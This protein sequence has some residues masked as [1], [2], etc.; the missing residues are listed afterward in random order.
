MSDGSQSVYPELAAHEL[1]QFPEREGRPRPGRLLYGAE[2]DACV[3]A[4][5]AWRESQALRRTAA[6][7]LSL[8]EEESPMEHWLR[9]RVRR[10]KAVDRE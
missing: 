1:D 10:S 2:R 8:L 4:H 7:Q 6:L 3:A 5:I 9:T